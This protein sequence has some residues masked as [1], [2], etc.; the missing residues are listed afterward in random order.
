MGCTPTMQIYK[1]FLIT[2]FL[3]I[4]KYFYTLFLFFQVIV[5]Y[6]IKICIFAF[7]YIIAEKYISD[8]D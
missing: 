2:L 6:K 7:Q 8:N 5:M 3:S 4:K 1:I